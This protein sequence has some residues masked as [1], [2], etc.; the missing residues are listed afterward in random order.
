MIWQSVTFVLQFSNNYKW[1]IK[2]YRPTTPP[3]PTHTNKH[4]HTHTLPKL[5]TKPNEAQGRGPSPKALQANSPMELC[6]L[7]GRAACT[8]STCWKGVHLF[9]TAAGNSCSQWLLRAKLDHRLPSSRSSCWYSLGKLAWN[10]TQQPLDTACLHTGGNGL[11]PTTY[12]ENWSKT[13]HSS[14]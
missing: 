5:K 8:S 4:T 3:S 10:H 14:R 9:S 7:S 6:S 13:T 11:K 12:W 1:P 2:I